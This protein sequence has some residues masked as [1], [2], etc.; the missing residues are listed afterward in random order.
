MKFLSQIA[1]A[2]YSTEGQKLK[3]FC[4]VFPNR[5]AGLFFQKYI[6]EIATEPLFSPAILTIKD[7]FTLLS[8]LKEVDRLEALFKLYSLYIEISGSKESFDEFVFWGDIILGDFD[9]VDKYLVDS[10]KLFANIKDIKDIESDYSFLSQKQ[11]E[12]VQTFWSN[13]LPVGDSEK[14]N[15]FRAIWETLYPLYMK[16]R[17]ELES[18]GIGYEG[19]IYRHVAEDILEKGENADILFNK[20]SEFRSVVFVGF[21]ALSSC[22]KVLLKALKNAGIADFY[23]DFNGDLIKDTNNKSSLFM[24]ENITLFPSRLNLDFNIYQPQEIEVIG[25]PSAVGEAKMVSEIIKKVG[26]GF[27]TAVV[28]PDE[29]LLMPILYSIPQEVESVNVT[30]GYPLKSGSVVSLMES[31][32]EL[33]KGSFYYKRVLPIL[34]HHYIKMIAKED[35]AKLVNKIAEENMVYVEEKEFSCNPLLKMIFRRSE[36]ISDYLLEI[37]EYLNNSVELTKIEKEFIY[38]FYTAVS[39]MRD[40]MIPMNTDTYCRLLLQIVNSTSIPF[41]GEPLAGLQIMGVLETRTLDFDNLIICSMNDGVFPSKTAVNSFIPF[42]LRK[43]FSMPDYE[44]KDG[45]AAYHFYR[46]IY[47]AK[48]VFLL[49]DTRSE[50]LQSGEVSRF[51][52]QLKYHFQVP[53]KESIA[54]FSV[55]SNKRDPIVIEKSPDLVEKIGKLFLKG[56]ESA[57]SS[58]SINTYVDCPLKFYFQYIKNVEEQE[59]VNEGVEADTFGSIFHTAMELLYNDYIGTIVTKDI[60]YTIL[61]NSYIIED[62]TNKAFKKVLKLKDIKGHN[63]LIQKLISRY[64]QQTVNYDISNCPFEYIASEKRLFFDYA[65]DNE[66]V[67]TIK[68]FIDRI[69]KRDGVQ[70][71][72]DYKTGSG[73]EKFNNCKDLFN[74]ANKKRNKIALQMILYVLMVYKSEKMIISPYL[75]RK[76][77]KE[78][79]PEMTVDREILDEFSES[80]TETLLKIT[81]SVTPFNQTEN[82]NICKYCPYTIICR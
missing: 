80:L 79:N 21:N 22:E 55:S 38:F 26:G 59:T 35:A 39:R 78:T 43:G 70:R 36:Q 60:L 65:L 7:L 82:E 12:A 51:I 69:D 49:Y 46:L 3:E 72:V 34:K 28:L 77:F 14:K 25:I 74:G 76:L 27:N 53:I 54:T 57:L 4:F 33:Q 63:L 29:S 66:C 1:N 40:L 32:M 67:V 24:S 47:R 52:H 6:G 11:L 45:V 37:L 15:Q 18:K 16:F 19:M 9:D 10:K 73:W 5:R 75:L 30:M 44:F 20:F 31:I 2:F 8:G 81:D 17:K 50:G 68:G 61:K 41:R 56:G 23:W 13:F 64:V 48:K 42:N 71:I 62:I 58:S